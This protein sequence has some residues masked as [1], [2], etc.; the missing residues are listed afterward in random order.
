MVKGVQGFY[1]SVL[2]KA[3]TAEAF[4][5]TDAGTPLARQNDEQARQ[6]GQAS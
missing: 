3:G 4:S 6:N 5:K 1:K 2:D